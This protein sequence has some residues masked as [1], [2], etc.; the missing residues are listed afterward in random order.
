MPPSVARL[1]RLGVTDDC[2][3]GA[4]QR[5]EEP[6]ICDGASV[7]SP[8]LTRSCA[9][10]GVGLTPAA[11]ILR[12]SQLPRQHADGLMLRRARLWGLWK[13]RGPRCAN[14]R[15]SDH[16]ADAPIVTMRPAA[17]PHHGSS[18]DADTWPTSASSRRAVPAARTDVLAPL[19]G[20]PRTAAR[21]VAPER[22]WRLLQQPLADAPATLARVRNA[23]SMP[24]DRSLAP[25]SLF[26]GDNPR[27]AAP[28]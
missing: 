5:S 21:R 10:R 22:P 7:S 12:T 3:F 27:E 15:R 4:A 18:G 17:T 26:T 13:Q 8:R 2:P 24:P 6:G 14:R 11:R 16:P 1:G 19:A 9:L 28:A 20:S 23:A 25:H